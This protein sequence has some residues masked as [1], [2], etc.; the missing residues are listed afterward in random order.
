MTD[1]QAQ[2]DNWLLKVERQ[3]E[4]DALM[5][6]E[7]NAMPPPWVCIYFAEQQERDGAADRAEQ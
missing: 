1:V 7:A 3:E 4:V 6:A 5:Q 2:Y